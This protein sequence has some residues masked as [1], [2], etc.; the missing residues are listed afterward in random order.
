[1][2]W[3]KFP[4]QHELMSNTDDDGLTFEIKKGE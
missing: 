3:T 4:N 2:K 1:M